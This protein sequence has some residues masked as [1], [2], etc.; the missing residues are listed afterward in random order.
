MFDQIE[1]ATQSIILWR[2]EE[3]IITCT[4]WMRTTQVRS[5]QHSLEEIFVWN[6]KQN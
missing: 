5:S 3:S 1:V 4:E 6:F 2:I